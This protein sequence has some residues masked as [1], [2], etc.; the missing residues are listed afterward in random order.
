MFHVEDGVRVVQRGKYY[1]SF[2][3][4]ESKSNASLKSTCTWKVPFTFD[5]DEMAY[6]IK[7]PCYVHNHSINDPNVSASGLTTISSLKHLLPSKIQLILSL[8]KFKLDLSKLREI[9]E[10]ANPGR[11]YSAALLSRLIEQGKRQF[12][13]D[14]PHSMTKFLELGI[15][16]RINGGVF[17]FTMTNEQRLEVAYLQTARMQLYSKIFNDFIIVDGTHNVCMYD[18]RLLPYTVVC[19][20]GNNITVL[21]HNLMSSVFSGKSYI[22]GYHLASSENGADISYGL[23]VF[24]LSKVGSTLMSDGGSA[25]PETA[26]KHKMIHILCS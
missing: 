26:A 7:S 6:T 15:A 3:A 10:G 20:L 16:V 21:M 18:L 22:A 4:T 19:S 1:C 25:Y 13:G 2:K 5:R 17:H 8:S 11:T 9:V 23:E 14:D 24:H 12:L